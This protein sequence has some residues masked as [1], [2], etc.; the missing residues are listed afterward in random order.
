MFLGVFFEKPAWFAAS[1]ASLLLVTP[2]SL[3]LRRLWQLRFEFTIIIGLLAVQ[4]AADSPLNALILAVYLM[5]LVNGMLL[6][7]PRTLHPS[8]W[9]T[10]IL[11][12]LVLATL[13][14]SDVFKDVG[15]GS[16]ESAFGANVDDY[17][18][19]YR[20][21]SY[22][23][24]I[25]LLYLAPHFVGVKSGLHAVLLLSSATLGSN[26]FG[27]IYAALFKAPATLAAA[28]VGLAFFALGII[29]FEQVEATAA[30]A[31]LWA[32]FMLGF[33]ECESVYGV[34]TDLIL[35]NNE[36]G[37]RS[38]HSIVLDFAWYGGYVGLLGGLIL[39]L[40]VACARSAFG[41]SASILFAVALLFGFPPFFN[42]RHVLVIYAFL[43][44]FQYKRV[45][46]VPDWSLRS[47]RTLPVQG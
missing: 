23:V 24:F 40:R 45:S 30:R 5:G 47:N 3:I 4:A 22:A 14:V 18:I 29:G 43:V 20:S 26:K 28:T 35:N 8:R 11:L 1:I 46:R 27:V 37:V 10:L 13:Y 2:P 34:C 6:P 21:L 25:I 38:F 36:E 17:Q 44:L 39:V 33:S 19:D 16:A 7:E 15:L 9:T 31:A 41:R 42:E 32:D 12:C